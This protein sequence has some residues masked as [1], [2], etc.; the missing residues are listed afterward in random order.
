MP[1]WGRVISRQLRHRHAISPNPGIRPLL[2]CWHYP[3]LAPLTGPSISWRR[4][5]PPSRLGGENERPLKAHS[6]RNQAA[7]GCGTSMGRGTTSSPLAFCGGGRF[8]GDPSTPFFRLAITSLSLA[9]L[10]RVGNCEGRRHGMETQ[11][12]SGYSTRTWGTHPSIAART[13][14]IIDPEATI[15]SYI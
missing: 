14:V 2:K 4:H 7:L 1:T 9:A 3:A 6:L 10:D 11:V 12:V 13:V 15:M 5:T 8:L